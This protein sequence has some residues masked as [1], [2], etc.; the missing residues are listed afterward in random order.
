MRTVYIQR[1]TEDPKEDMELIKTEVDLFIDGRSTAGK[2][3]GLMELA[4]LTAN[5]PT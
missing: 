5:I 3:G 1:D 2:E 4:R